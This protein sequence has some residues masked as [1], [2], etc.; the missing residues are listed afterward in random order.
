VFFSLDAE[1]EPLNDG[2][3]QC[4]GAQSSDK[5]QAN[6]IEGCHVIYSFSLA[7]SHGLDEKCGQTNDHYGGE[8]GKTDGV[9]GAHVTCSSWAPKG[10][11]S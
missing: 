9:K 10:P 1:A 7:W 8:V 3:D 11:R 2:H 6:N 5:R 4:E